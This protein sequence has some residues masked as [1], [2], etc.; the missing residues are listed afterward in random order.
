MKLLYIIVI[1]WGE[2]FWIFSIFK[3]FLKILNEKYLYVEVDE[4]DLS[5]I[6]LFVVL[7]IN[8]KV[9]YLFMMGG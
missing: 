6:E 5:I 4:F 1:I 9:K 7:D 8:V 2:E 3:E